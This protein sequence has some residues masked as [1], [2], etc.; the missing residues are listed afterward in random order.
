MCLRY[1]KNSNCT[2]ISA[3]QVKVQACACDGLSGGTGDLCVAGEDG[4]ICRDVVN[5]SAESVDITD[6]HCIWKPFFFVIM[7]ESCKVGIE[8][9]NWCLTVCHGFLCI[10]AYYNEGQSW[11]ADTTFWDPPH[12]ISTFQSSMFIGSPKEAET[13]STTVRMPYFFR[14][15]QI[16]EISLSIPL[17]VSP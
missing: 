10:I 1:F 16:E 14:S 13:E 15:G 5:G 17:G 12:M 4:R 3:V 11:S 9:S 7:C 6:R 2:G 8:R